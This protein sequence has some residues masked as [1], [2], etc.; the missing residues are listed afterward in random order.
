M[1][2]NHF[3]LVHKMVLQIYQGNTNWTFYQEVHVHI[4]MAGKH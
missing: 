2:G 1:M 3:I 4:Y